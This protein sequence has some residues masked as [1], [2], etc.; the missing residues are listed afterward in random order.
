MRIVFACAVVAAAKDLAGAF[1]SAKASVV[2]LPGSDQDIWEAA[3]S[4]KVDEDKVDVWAK[5]AEETVKNYEDSSDD[6]SD[7][8]DS[9]DEDDYL[10]GNWEDEEWEGRWDKDDEWADHWDHDDYNPAWDQYDEDD[11]GYDSHKENRWERDWDSSYQGD[12]KRRHY[13]EEP[14]WLCNFFMGFMH[15]LLCGACCAGCIACVVVPA[16]MVKKQYTRRQEHDAAITQAVTNLTARVSQIQYQQY[17][18]QVNA[19]NQAA[20]PAAQSSAPKQ[21][22]Q[23]AQAPV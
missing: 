8:S 6:S 1:E 19:Q 9:S 17:Q 14:D 18:Q 10:W 23:P 21:P 15:V 3:K 22:A 2:T 16:R 4:V 20:Q 5:W 7:W 11:W 12:R 13:T